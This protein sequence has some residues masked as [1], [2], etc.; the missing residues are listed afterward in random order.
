LRELETPYKVG[1]PLLAP[2]GLAGAFDSHGVDVPFVFR[3]QGRFHMLYV[4][5][6]GA[7]YQTALATSE[8]LLRW[9]HDA[10]V[11]GRDDSGRWDS[12]SI[13]G[14]CI[15]A[16]SDGRYWLTYHAYPGAG[17]ETGPAEIGMA[18]T[19]DATLR[20]W[21]RLDAP[22]LSWRDG[23]PWERGGLYASCI[24]EDADRFVMLYNA[25]NDAAAW[26]EQIGVATSTDLVHWE[27]SGANPVV[28]TSSAGWDSRFVAD[29][30]VVR[31]GDRWAMVFYGFD[32]QHAQNGLAYSD[33]LL[34]WQKEPRP[35]LGHGDAGDPDEIHAHK[36]SLV[37]EGG[38]VYHFYCAVRPKR[39][40]DPTLAT[41]EFRTITVAT[42]V[43]IA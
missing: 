25:K 31:H 16:A 8:D 22:V 28:R 41:D 24:I 32:G 35:I 40:G 13:A 26:T 1:R 14:T 37:I 27:R 3:H 11:L 17:Y 20:S 7:G 15:L 12:V 9:E 10:I 38:V 23:A 30:H 19:D 21:H 39:A 43:P 4:G 18:W 6:D 5:F 36:G 29:P 2:S 34:R 42:S 33:D